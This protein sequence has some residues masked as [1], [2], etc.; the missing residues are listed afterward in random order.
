MESENT[1]EEAKNVYISTIKDTIP[2][3][4]LLLSQTMEKATRT[5]FDSFLSIIP[6]EDDNIQT[7]NASCSIYSLYPLNWTTYSSESMLDNL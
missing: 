3:L 6:I 5:A 1:L 2:S 7:H 4:E